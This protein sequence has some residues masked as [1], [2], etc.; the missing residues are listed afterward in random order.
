MTPKRLGPVSTVQEYLETVWTTGAPGGSGIRIFRGQAEDK[1]LL[2][3]LFRKGCDPAKLGEL[4]HW[5]LYQFQHRCLHL[6][7]T[8]PED[9][10]NCLSLAQHYGLPTRL[11]DWS[12]N[13]LMALFFAV[14]THKPHSPV[15]WIF[16]PTMAQMLDGARLH[17]EPALQDHEKTLLIEPTPHSHRVVAQAGFHTVH[18]MGRHDGSGIRPM[19]DT[20]ADRLTCIMVDP[21]QWKFLRDELRSMG[22][23]AATVYGDLNSVCR[24]IES[25]CDFSPAPSQSGTTIT[26]AES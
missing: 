17:T 24:E 5:L 1:P 20:E 22:I 8:N 2:P 11:L 10:Y 12:T 25:E 9:N 23:H 6:L 18:S 4:E 21:D 15:V 16:D 26:T 3:R 19:N 14:D 13:P 7:P